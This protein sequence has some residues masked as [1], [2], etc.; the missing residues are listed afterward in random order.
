MKETERMNSQNRILNVKGPWSETSR[1]QGVFIPGSP[2]PEGR[3]IAADLG[4]QGPKCLPLK[5]KC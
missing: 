1:G 5:K 4:Q 3:G 2:A